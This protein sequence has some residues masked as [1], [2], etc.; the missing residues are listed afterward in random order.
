MKE[1]IGEDALERFAGLERELQSAFGRIEA[2]H[3]A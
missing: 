1:E 2:P 3:A